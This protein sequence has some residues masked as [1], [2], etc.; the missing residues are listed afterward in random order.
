MGLVYTADTVV[1]NGAVWELGAGVTSGLAGQDIVEGP[2]ALLL[3]RRRPMIRND[4]TPKA[5]AQRYHLVFILLSFVQSRQDVSRFFMAI[6]ACDGRFVW[7][8]E[9]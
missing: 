7:V 8:E 1:V 9:R 6:F 2:A 5:T 4:P 3:D